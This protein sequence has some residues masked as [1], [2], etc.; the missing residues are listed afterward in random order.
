MVKGYE[1]ETKFASNVELQKEANM[2]DMYKLIV[3]VGIFLGICGIALI[4]KAGESML[5]AVV[6]I[7]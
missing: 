5:R 3:A 7:P 1:F 4:A 6:P 2:K